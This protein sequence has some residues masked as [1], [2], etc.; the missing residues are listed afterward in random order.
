MIFADPD[1]IAYS[2]C[3]G[4]ETAVTHNG[5]AVTQSKGEVLTVGGEP[6]GYIANGDITGEDGT[7][8]ASNI[9]A[10]IAEYGSAVPAAFLQKCVIVLIAD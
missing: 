7:V 10:V 2:G 9:D 6:L 3:R 4:N 5:E 8:Y 1:S